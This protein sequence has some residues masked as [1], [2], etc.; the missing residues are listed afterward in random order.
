MVYLIVVVALFFLSVKGLCGKKTS[1]YMQDSG[2]AFRFNILRMLLCMLIGIV[3]VFIENAERYLAVESGILWICILAGVCNAAFL[4]GWMLAVRTNAMITVD[5]SLT[6]GSMIPAVLCAIL[7]A[8]PISLPKMVGFALILLA[9]AILAGYRKEDKKKG[10]I[11]GVVFVIF[12]SVGEGTVSFT[13]QL[14]KQFY[15]ESGTRVGD[16]IYPKSVYHFYTYVFSAA[17]LLLVLIGYEVWRHI[18]NPTIGWIDDAKTSLRTL[19]K[20]LP[21]IVVMAISMFA[22]TYFQTVATNDYGMSSQVLYPLIKGGCLITVT[23]YAMIFFGERV[24]RR[25]ILGTTVA[26]AGILVMNIL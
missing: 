4:V 13:Q 20:P 24:T 18:K 2:D 11:G 21:Y 1:T 7:F 14:Y 23:L 26:M 12:A 10:S 17:A 3:L 25:S 6:L 5:V 9:A 19:F 16:V 15:T 8:E 22:A